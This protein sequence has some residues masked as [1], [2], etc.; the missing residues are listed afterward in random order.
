MP[1]FVDY[2]AAS[3]VLNPSTTSGGRGRGLA[4]GD[5]DGDGDLDILLGGSDLNVLI[6]DGIA[7]FTAGTV[8]AGSG[9]FYAD[10]EG[11][12]STP[13]GMFGRIEQNMC[14][15]GNG[16]G[17]GRIALG[18]ADGDGDLDAALIG[19]SGVFLLLND[20]SASFTNHGGGSDRLTGA[21]GSVPPLL[22]NGCLEWADVDGDSD[23]DLVYV[24]QYQQGDGFAST[25]SFHGIY[26]ALNDG[27]GSF[28]W[29]DKTPSYQDTNDNT[30]TAIPFM[31][32]DADRQVGMAIAD[33]DLDGD[34]DVLAAEVIL[35]NDG[36]GTLTMQ[37]DD[38]IRAAKDDG[39][40]MT[41]LMGDLDSDGYPD[42]V[43]LRRACV[44]CAV[45]GL[46][47][48]YRNKGEGVTAKGAFTRVVGSVVGAIQADAMGGTLGDY[49]GDGYR[50]AAP[51]L[52]CSALPPFLCSCRSFALC[53]EQ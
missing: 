34:V 50:A 24:H 28:A 21:D 36:T 47:A 45:E 9:L 2:A 23:L 38:E 39:I 5:L 41:V 19:T 27:S 17:G 40:I 18:D 6:N 33:I 31:K 22:D 32:E 29:V 1:S 3:T 11:T 20:G 51:T 46:S 53:Y 10:T 7:G 15:G 14:G 49:D 8:V 13:A 52:N 30:V 26:V 25:D 35:V 12:S 43:I 44:S 37:R 42:A 48:V 16:A 4:V